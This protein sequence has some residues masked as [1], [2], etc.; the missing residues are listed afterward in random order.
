MFLVAF[1]PTVRLYVF[2]LRVQVVVS[3]EKAVKLC[4]RRGGVLARSK[5][6]RM[7]RLVLGMAMGGDDD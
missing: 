1:L 7:W 2:G 4:V 3:S 6:L 5:V